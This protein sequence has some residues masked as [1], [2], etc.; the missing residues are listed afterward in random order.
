MAGIINHTAK[1][2][3]LKALE[4][5]TNRIIVVR[6]HPGFNVV[7]DDKWNAVKGLEY[8]KAL[9]AADKIDFGTALNKKEPKDKSE[10]S[11]TKA[12]PVVDKKKSDK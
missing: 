2:F 5:K 6:I 3:N 9:K 10:I 1:Q 7:D 4:P 12:A 11:K 8:V